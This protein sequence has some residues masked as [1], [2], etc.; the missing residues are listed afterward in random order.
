MLE[1]SDSRQS[2]SEQ[3]TEGQEILNQT[4]IRFVKEVGGS[5]T[6]KG[7]VSRLRIPNSSAANGFK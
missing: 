6:M 3:D 7:I 5:D 1:N 4:S 2:P